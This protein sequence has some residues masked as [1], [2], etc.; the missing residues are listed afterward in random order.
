MKRKNFTQEQ[1]EHYSKD[2]RVK[3]ID[4]NKLVLTYEFRLEI[5][6]AIK[7]NLC[8]A[9][10]RQYL[11]NNNFI[12]GKI[13][14]DWFTSTINKFK[15]NKPCG[16]K[17][18]TYGESERINSQVDKTYD[19]YLLSTG[20][21]IKGRNGISITDEV[22]HEL[23]SVYPNTSIEDYLTS[24]GLDIS[25]IGYYRIYNIKRLFDSNE[26]NGEIN[27]K[28]DKVSIPILSSNPYTKR[29]NSNQFTLKDN[30][31]NEAIEFKHLNIVKV[32]EIFDID[33]KL[34]PISTLERIKYKLQNWKYKECDKLNIDINLSNKILKNKCEAIQ[35]FV[36]CGFNVV[37]NYLKKCSK[38]EKK[39][40]I[41]MFDNLDY[42]KDYC[43][44][45]RQIMSK[46]GVS[47]SSYYSILKNEKYGQFEADKLENDNKDIEIIKE[48]IDYKGMP[49][50]SRTIFMMLPKLKGIKMSRNKIIRLCRKANLKCDVRKVNYSRQNMQ[51]LLKENCKD[52]LVKRKFKLVKPGKITLTDV[53]YL[54]YGSNNKRAYLSAIKDSCSGKVKLI[55]SQNN[56]LNL[57]LDTLVL[58][59]GNDTKDKIFH[60]DQGGL[61]LTTTF[62]QK[63][64]ELGYL[65]SMSKRGNCWDNAPQESFFGHMKDECDFSKCETIDE[66]KIY[67]SK[68]EYYYNYERPQWNR[69]KMTPVQFEEY[70]LNMTEDEYQRYY[71]VEL[72]KY[73]QMME[74]AKIKAINRAKTLGIS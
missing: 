58:L 6:E 43:Y 28:M 55:V 37:N 21:F 69:L 20:K 54:S 34:I 12:F 62:Q 15:I 57:A 5:Y 27:T 50:G 72:A 33:Y 1:I 25:R 26:D 13:G 51:K 74:N 3:F 32:L 11:S 67:I 49:K 42:S 38:L 4:E 39:E 70:I 10:L 68:Y 36:E 22:L 19:E 24:L 65:Q 18:K 2:P 23:Y 46:I 53:S 16:A 41:K 73:N 48:V 64:K 47:K 14:T 8:N 40:I 61:Y 63:L 30:F 66:L 60:S 52:N 56:D 9:S 45:K 59:H 31:Y 35:K 71:E 17:N 7:G 29:V 44:T